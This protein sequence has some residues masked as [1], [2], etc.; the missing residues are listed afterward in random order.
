VVQNVVKE[1]S[2]VK[3]MR[4]LEIIHQTDNYSETDANR[5]S[6][7]RF[8]TS[9]IAGALAKLWGETKQTKAWKQLSENGTNEF[10]DISMAYWHGWRE[11]EK[12]NK[13]KTEKKK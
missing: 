5:L 1:Q 10:N 7:N 9:L 8:Y 11:V 13:E 4:L 2:N 3:L 12:K 6:D